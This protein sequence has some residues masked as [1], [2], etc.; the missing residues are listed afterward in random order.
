MRHCTVNTVVASLCILLLS[1][2]FV[3][4]DDMEHQEESEEKDESPVESNGQSD[5]SVGEESSGEQ[6]SPCNKIAK[7]MQE[8]PRRL[9]NFSLVNS[10]ATSEV[11][12][13]PA[14]GS[15]LKLSC[16]CHTLPG[17]SSEWLGTP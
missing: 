12:S 8:C 2:F 17:E 7:K 11:G 16:K 6:C 15:A 5:D 9:F 14:E 1:L 13:M 3:L 4:D 10:Y